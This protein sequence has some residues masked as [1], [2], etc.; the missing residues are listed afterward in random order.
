MPW[1]HWWN[2]DKGGILKDWS[3]T[4]YPT[5]YVLDSEGVIRYKNIRGQELEEVVEKLLGEVKDKK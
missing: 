1:T 4:F 5:I 2:G 3:V